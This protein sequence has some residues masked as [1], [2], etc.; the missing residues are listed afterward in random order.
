MGFYK[1]DSNLILAI[2]NS[3]MSVGFLCHWLSTYIS[4]LFDA[5]FIY[6]P[7]DVECL[8]GKLKRGATVI[9][10][11]TDLTSPISNISNI[12][13]G[14]V[15]GYLDRVVM[16]IASFEVFHMRDVLWRAKDKIEIGWH[17]ASFPMRCIV[18]L[19]VNF[20]LCK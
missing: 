20:S 12:D 1:R 3:N 4:T 13:M 17:F 2:V 14:K 15:V 8:Q 18:R 6:R 5:F 16:E 10:N 11:L 19:E 7:F 9:S